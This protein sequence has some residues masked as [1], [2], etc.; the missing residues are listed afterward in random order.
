[1]IIIP[2]TKTQRKKYHKIIRNKIIEHYSEGKFECNCCGEKEYEFLTLDHINNDGNIER[3]KLG[4]TGL[5]IYRQILKDN[6]PPYYQI[7]CMNCNIS[8]AK[9]GVCI[10]KR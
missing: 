7:L 9:T 8:K 4:N 3:K 2:Y 5:I 6:F 1:M 10:H